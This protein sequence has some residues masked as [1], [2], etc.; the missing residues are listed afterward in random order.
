MLARPDDGF[1]VPAQQ[2]EEPPGVGALGL[3][4]LPVMKA[5]HLA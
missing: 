3:A 1:H 2:Q 5:D 4:R